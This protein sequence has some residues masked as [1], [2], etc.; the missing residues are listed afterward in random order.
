[1]DL[2]P[3][4]LFVTRNA[5]NQPETW[6]LNWCNACD[7]DLLFRQTDILGP[8]AGVTTLTSPT[9]NELVP[10][11]PVR[12]IAEDVLV[13]FTRPGSG[14]YTYEIKITKDEAGNVAVGT[15]RYPAD[16]EG[17]MV[18]TDSENIRKLMGPNQTGDQYIS[19]NP[20]AN[21]YAWVRTVGPWISQWV[22][23]VK[24]QIGTLAAAAPEILSPPNGSATVGE[25]PAFSW[26]PT[27]GATSYRFQLALNPGMSAPIADATVSSTGY[28]LLESLDDGTTYYW[29]VM[30]VQ[31]VAGDWS[32]VAN[33]TVFVAE[34]PTQAPPP[35][36]ITQIPPPEIVL[37][38]PTINLPAPQEIVIP[39]PPAAV[40]IV[41]V[42]IYIIIAIG[43]LLVIVVI[44]LIVRTRRP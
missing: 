7:N 43:A 27:A 15:Y 29:R 19:F 23:G 11:N 44:I 25:R 16:D 13:S 37:P 30:A 35:I 10:M 14:S 40:Q 6:T 26:S 33:F 2:Y 31:P 20:G 17:D 5:D 8:G 3:H 22:G 36:T 18:A 21:Y 9:A 1:M 42:Y 4:A 38:A 39:P 28:R 41:P 12:G 24:F 32:A 34:A